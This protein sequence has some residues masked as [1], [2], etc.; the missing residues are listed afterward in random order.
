MNKK[1]FTDA[2]FEAYE[3]SDEFSEDVNHLLNFYDDEDYSVSFYE[4]VKNAF[5]GISNY[6]VKLTPSEMLLINKAID[7]KFNKNEILA[8]KVLLNLNKYAYDSHTL[9][10]VFKYPIER[11]YQVFIDELPS[12]VDKNIFCKYFSEY[13]ANNGLDEQA[14][15]NILPYNLKF[16]SDGYIIVRTSIDVLAERAKEDQ[17]ENYDEDDSIYIENIDDLARQ[18]RS[19]L[20]LPLDR[21]SNKDLVAAFYG[22]WDMDTLYDYKFFL[23]RDYYKRHKDDIL[24]DI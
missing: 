4:I 19:L 2:L 7:G 20:K 15:K 6:S 23:L 13:L 8:Y 17:E 10:K 11:I 5:N 21:L 16:T 1:N 12:N 3:K 14:V 24:S 22:I 9:A 18:I